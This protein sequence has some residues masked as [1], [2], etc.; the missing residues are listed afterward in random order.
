LA[1][2]AAGTGIQFSNLTPAWDPFALPPIVIDEVP[3]EPPR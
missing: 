1:T 3:I 2:T